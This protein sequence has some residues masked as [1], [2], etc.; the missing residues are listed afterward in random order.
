MDVLHSLGHNLASARCSGNDSFL[1]A[2]ALAGCAFLLSV[3]VKAQTAVAHFCRVHEI[4]QDDC[5]A[6][7]WL[8]FW[9]GCHHSFQRSLLG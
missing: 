7:S 3:V 1:D 4:V 9:N 8:K 6:A 2:R 5:S